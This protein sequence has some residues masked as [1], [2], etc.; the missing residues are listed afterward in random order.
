MNNMWREAQNNFKGIKFKNDFDTEF[1]NNIILNPK[2]IREY[3]D[4]NCKYLDKTPE[5]IKNFYYINNYKGRGIGDIFYNLYCYIALRITIDR[6]NH[7]EKEYGRIKTIFARYDK[8]ATNELLKLVRKIALEDYWLPFRRIAINKIK[9]NAIYN[10]GLGLKLAIKA[11][12][13]DF[14]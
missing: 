10:N 6:P 5:G 12:K 4:A 13:E 7:T 14:N 3:L 2:Y 9:R 8:G 1:V 11:F